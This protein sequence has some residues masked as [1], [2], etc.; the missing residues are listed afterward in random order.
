MGGGGEGR[1]KMLPIV[2]R[3]ERDD[4]SMVLIL[5]VNLRT[6]VLPPAVTVMCIVPYLNTSTNLLIILSSNNENPKKYLLVFDFL[7]V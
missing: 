2:C 6:T 7:L 5:T 3:E 4:F 1:R